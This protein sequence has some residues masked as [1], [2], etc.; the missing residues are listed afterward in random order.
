MK[1]NFPITGNEVIVDK[2]ANILSTTDLKGAITYINDDFIKISGFSREELIGKNHNIVR[3]PEMPP[4]T[5]EHLWATIKTGQPWMGMVK[6][7]CKNGDHYWVSAYVTPIMRNGEIIE[8]QSVR[9]KPTREQIQKAESIYAELMAGRKPR[10]MRLPH[11]NL[12][13]KLIG[14]G[15]I[16]VLTGLAGGAAL[17]EVSLSTAAIVG[18]ITMLVGGVLANFAFLPICRMVGYVRHIANNPISQLIYTNKLDEAGEIELTLKMLQAEASAVVGRIADASHHLMGAADTLVDAVEQSG[19]GIRQQQSETDQVATAITEMSASVQEVARNAQNTADAADKADN[20]A[21]EGHQVVG[22]TSSAIGRLAG[23]IE[24]AAAVIQ[25]LEERSN[26][27]SSVLEVIRG[28]ADQTN[29]L[30]LNAAIEAARAGEQ[31]RGFAVVA[32][33]VRTL[34]SRTQQSTQEIQTMIENLQAGA[35]SAVEVMQ[36]SRKQ[37]DNSVDQARLAASSLNSITSSVGVITDMSAQIAA[38]VEEQSAVSEEINRNIISIRQVSDAN[39]RTGAES[40]QVAQN[41]SSLA[42]S[43]DQ[44][45]QQF[46]DKRH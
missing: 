38:A 19:E 3:H 20:E 4:A 40:E 18:G 33:E 10:K 14:S 7:R 8:Y 2:N 24:K 9:T 34:A 16:G 17:G 22:N 29:L 26:D 45:A 46:W 42:T 41:V 37:A 6:N 32:D 13:T 1:K 28:I 25:Q 23:E 27:I 44:L 35:R 5:F 21:R 12:R 36:L 31:G 39:A 11:I 15:G 43:L 30:A